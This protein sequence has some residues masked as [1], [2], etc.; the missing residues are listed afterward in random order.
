MSEPPRPTDPEHPESE[1]REALRQ[2]EQELALLRETSLAI[3]TELDLDTVF[4]LIASHARRLIHARTVLVPVINRD[5]NEYTYRAGDGENAEEIVGESLP[6]DFGVCGW[7]WKHKRP[8]WRATLSELSPQERNLWEREAGTLILV[9]LM[10]HKDFLGGIAGINKEGGG[11]FTENDLHLL[12]LFAGQAAIAIENA[13]AM[14][15]TE[16][17]LRAAGEAQAELKR[18]NKRLCAANEA[19]EYLS[20]YDPLTNLPNRSLFRE[21]LRED[22][23]QAKRKGT[24][25]ALL[26]AD[27]DRFLEINDTL[28]HDAGDSMLKAAAERFTGPV[29][30]AGGLL[31][32]MSGD[33]FAVLLEADAAGATAVAERM[34]RKLAQPLRL[35]GHEVIATAAVGIALYPAHGDDISS[36]F[37]SA[38]AAML[39]AK[40]TGSGIRVFDAQRDAGALDRFALTQDLRKAL[41][42]GE[43]RL[44]YQPKIEL[45]TGAIDGVEALARWHRGNGTMV[46]PDMFICA[47]EQTGLIAPFTYWALERAMRQR[48]DWLRRGWDIHIAVNVPLS[49]VLDAHFLPELSRIVGPH[50]GSN[51]GLVLEITE[52]IFLGD[53]DRINGILADLRDFGMGFSIDDFGTGHSSL[54]RLRQLPVGEIKVDRSFVVAMLDN[55]DDEA[56]VRSTIDLAHNLGLKVVAEGVE[57]ADI[58]VALA[59]LGCDLVQGY[60]ISR[61]LP[62]DELEK[63]VAHAGWSVR[64]AARTSAEG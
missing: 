6:L 12:E 10:G 20:L 57:N 36:L 39:A 25:L 52:N 17:A 18:M 59:R 11:E 4:K 14:E 2:R 56:I 35:T 41:D 44:H 33:E 28:G 30:K 21:R 3:G 32:R 7:V 58:M 49:V 38:D 31:A 64:A 26:I 15:D 29:E 54:A 24:S 62:A 47:L 53:Y 23:A 34:R 60:H 8:W 51:T 50:R 42:D 5:G 43:F 13:M 1:L 16:R 9:P 48:T 37:K 55:A 46:P 27:L 61:A 63:F 22:I 45:A 40:Q 19:L